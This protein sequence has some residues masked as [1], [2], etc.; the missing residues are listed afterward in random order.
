MRA[1]EKEKKHNQGATF[2]M[3]A[4]GHPHNELRQTVSF[5]SKDSCRRGSARERRCARVQIIMK[6]PL[7][8]VLPAAARQKLEDYECAK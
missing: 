4:K 6:M 1:E 7:I 2:H 8:A 3:C 5:S